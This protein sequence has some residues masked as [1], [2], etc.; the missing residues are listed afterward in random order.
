M[1]WDVGVLGKRQTLSDVRAWILRYMIVLFEV[2]LPLSLAILPS[3]V[4][5]RNK[6]ES[7][8]PSLS[9]G[10]QALAALNGLRGVAC[11]F[12]FNYHLL[13]VWTHS[14]DI[15]WGTVVDPSKAGDD[16]DHPYTDQTYFL[17]LP[18]IRLFYAGHSMVIVFFVISGYVLSHKPIKLMRM[19]NYDQFQTVLSSSVF[20]RGIRLFGPTL[21]GTAITML[22]TTMG[23]FEAGKAIDDDQVIY[24]GANEAQPIMMDTFYGQLEHWTETMGN[25]ISNVWD[26][27]IYYNSYDA[28][29]WTIPLEFRSSM[30]LFLTQIAFSRLRSGARIFLTC[31]MVT[32]CFYYWVR[33]EV[34][35]FLAGML[36]AELDFVS[37]L[38][39]E[40]PLLG[41]KP[42]PIY[43]RLSGFG[44]AAMFFLGCF[45]NSCPTLGPDISPGYM[46]ISSIMPARY[47]EGSSRPIQALGGALLVWSFMHLPI[48]QRIF[49]TSVAQYLGKISYAFYIVHGPIL[50]M[51]G[52]NL[53]LL[54]WSYTGRETAVGFG[55]GLVLGALVL[56]PIAIWVADIFWRAIDTPCVDFA[57]WVETRLIAPPED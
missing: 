49:T 51:F 11:V 5:G 28:H 18:I 26:W 22:L 37:G 6:F 24:K 10:K 41:E 3:F 33:W 30:V 56:L 15:S 7:E 4:R 43:H 17:Q 52:Y 12:V 57:R 2:I 20:R 50:H 45:L 23:L 47:S 27:G 40:R 31:A 8:Q 16:P 38:F 14:S 35:L 48:V 36:S 53:V 19:G 21:I 29:L 34:F 25:M 39:V 13:F 55:S 9:G 32:M 1:E 44:W 46:Y 54:I 42:L